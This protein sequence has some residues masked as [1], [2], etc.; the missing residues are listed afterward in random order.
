MILVKKGAIFI[1]DSIIDSFSSLVPIARPIT[2]IS[3]S[4]LH[5]DLRRSGASRESLLSA[6]SFVITHFAVLASKRTLSAF[7]PI[8]K[9]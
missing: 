4:H 5:I 6:S 8:F 1:I 7:F 2:A 9:A 3:G